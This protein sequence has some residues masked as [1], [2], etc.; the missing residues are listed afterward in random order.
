MEVIRFEHHLELLAQFIE[1]P[2]RLHARDPHWI[3]PFRE[4]VRGQLAAD[5]DFRAHARMVHFLAYD[6]RVVVA[7]CSAMIDP[8]YQEDG[9]PLGLIGFFEA[10]D[11]YEAAAAVLQEAVAWLGAQGA[12]K[13]RGPINTSTYHTYRFMIEGFELGSFFLEPYNPPYYPAYWEQF[14]FQQCCTYF[15]AIVGSQECADNLHR[16]YERVTASGLVFRKF[17]PSR[18]DEELRRMY[19]IASTIFEGVYMYRPIAFEEFKVLYGGMKNLMVPELSYF[20]ESEGQ[21]LGFVFGMP[22]YGPAIRAMRGDRDWRAKLRF[23]LARPQ[24]TIATLKTFGVVPGRRQGANALALCYKMQEAAAR[25]GYPDTI[26]AL[27]R[28]D[29]VSL[30]MSERRGGRKNKRYALFEYDLAAR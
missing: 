4:T 10:T 16:E 25:L 2:Y 7:R 13:V 6:G 5:S 30:R 8:R 22:E 12:R 28:E 27:M 20:L 3:P 21:P 29:N 19:D 1:L 9:V 26:H 18:F 23:A 15:S 17:D 11:R 14:G 24:C